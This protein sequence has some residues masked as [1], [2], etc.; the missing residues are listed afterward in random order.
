M[1]LQ[2]SLAENNPAKSLAALGQRLDQ[3]EARLE[4][5]FGDVSARLGSD[6]LQVVEDHVKELST[7]FEATSRQLARLDTIDGQLQQ[8]ARA[9]EEQRSRRRR[10][11]RVW[12]RRPSRR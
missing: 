8:L 10:N 12:P 5:L 6:W 2:Q 7:Q 4:T 11:P 9:H 1:A 3:M